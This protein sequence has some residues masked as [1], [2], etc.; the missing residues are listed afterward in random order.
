MTI[1]TIVYFEF[2]M[3]LYILRSLESDFSIFAMMSVCFCVYGGV[4][5]YGNLNTDKDKNTKLKF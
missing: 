5:I 4:Y 3:D 2:W 1:C